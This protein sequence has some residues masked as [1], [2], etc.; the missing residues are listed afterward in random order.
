M[1]TKGTLYCPWCGQHENGIG[2]FKIISKTAESIT[3]QCRIHGT[4]VLFNKGA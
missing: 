2:R 4:W 3:C 1:T